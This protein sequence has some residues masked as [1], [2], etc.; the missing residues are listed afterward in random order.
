M[1]GGEEPSGAEHAEHD[2][3]DRARAS[4]WRIAARHEELRSAER[5]NL[6]RATAVALLYAAEVA[7]HRGWIPAGV[8][9]GSLDDAL[10]FHR[11]ATEIALAWALVSAGVLVALR[12]RVF[13][14]ALKFVTTGAD[15]ALASALIAIG[16][17]PQSGF[18]FLYFPILALA[19]LRLE[20]WLVHFATSA[21]ILSYLGVVWMA[22]RADP[23][24]AV[25]RHH[26]VL[27]VLAIAV[28][29]LALAYAAND[30]RRVA[31]EYAARERRA[32]P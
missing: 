7:R 16:G 26:S 4:A 12:N 9:P 20:P 28:V 27:V 24:L 32:L 25:P 11:I 17:G 18:V 8:A 10:A 30:V 14:P 1:G 13:P 22:E 29:G 5:V 31:A 21:S 15:V 19:T 2:A 3:R 23:D 6:L